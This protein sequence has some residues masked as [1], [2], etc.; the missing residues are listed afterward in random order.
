MMTVETM[1]AMRV[2]MKDDVMVG[3]L[4]DVKAALMVDWMVA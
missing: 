1:A 3:L 4:V 2:G